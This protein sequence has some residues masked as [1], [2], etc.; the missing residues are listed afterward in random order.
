MGYGL[1]KRYFMGQG[2][3]TTVMARTIVANS[4]FAQDPGEP[5]KPLELRRVYATIKRF[6]VYDLLLSDDT[7]PGRTMFLLDLLDGVVNNTQQQHTVF[8][9]DTGPVGITEQQ[10]P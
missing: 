2:E 3:M 4:S 10:V 8:V 7:A 9:A 5:G 6:G 1:P